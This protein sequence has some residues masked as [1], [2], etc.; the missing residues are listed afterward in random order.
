MC[1]IHILRLRCG[2]PE[3][4]NAKLCLSQWDRWCANQTVNDSVSAA[5][6]ASPP[7][8]LVEAI[9]PDCPVVFLDTASVP[10]PEV[11]SGHLVANEVEA[12]LAGTLVN[13][14]VAAG[15]AGHAIGVI[16]PYQ[17]QLKLL[18][19][20]MA[21]DHPRVEISTIDKYQGRDKECIIMSLVRS[22]PAGGLGDL[23]K[24]WRRV[25]VAVTRAKHKLII[26]GDGSTL[27]RLHLAEALL[28]VVDK[29]NWRRALPRGAHKM[30]AFHARG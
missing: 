19:R 17:T 22:S 28:E 5:S 7:T 15:L 9:D 30:A 20:R 4:A 18:R 6:P 1:S 16:S 8:W 13:G 21:S 23:L 11:R 24:D 14:L 3:I 26:I 29:F 2:T 10:A 25:N 12:E 27:Q